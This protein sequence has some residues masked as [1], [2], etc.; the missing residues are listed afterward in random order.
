MLLLVSSI[1]LVAEIALMAF[2]GRFVL[3]LLVGNR[4]AGNP[5]F[6]VLDVLTRPF[7]T[8]T[9]RVTP[10]VVIDRHVPIVAFLLL[11]MIWIA[12]TG[13]KIRLCL[14]VGIELCR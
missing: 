12:A 7:V 2:L 9:R 1:K 3:G 11:V 14:Q 13:A 8:F 10:R 5:F 4:R 6:G